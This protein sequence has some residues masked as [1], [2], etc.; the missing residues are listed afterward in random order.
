LGYTED[1][2]LLCGMAMGYEDPDAA[3]NAYRVPR[4]EVSVFSRFFD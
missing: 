2:I 1:S 3:I 4:E